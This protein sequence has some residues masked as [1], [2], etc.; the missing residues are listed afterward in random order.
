MELVKDLDSDQVLAHLMLN[1]P[2]YYGDSSQRELAI[3]LTDYLAKHLSESYQQ[4]SSAARILC[5][6]IKNQRLG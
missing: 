2:N 4:D 6:M 1:I 3:E 5:E